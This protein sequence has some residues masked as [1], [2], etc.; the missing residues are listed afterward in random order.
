MDD[1]L[2]DEVYKAV[3]DLFLKELDESQDEIF[4]F[5]PIHFKQKNQLAIM[6]A[7]AAAKVATRQPQ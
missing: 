4:M 7:T 2:Y 6:A 5:I 3:F 1:K